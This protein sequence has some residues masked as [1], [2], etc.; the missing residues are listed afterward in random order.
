MDF[1]EIIYLD[2]DHFSDKRANT[3]VGR[4]GRHSIIPR[5]PYCWY[6]YRPLSSVSIKRYPLD[7]RPALQAVLRTLL[8]TYSSFLSSILV[9]PPSQTSDV[10]P[11][12]QRLVE[13]MRVM[14]QNI[15][16][17][18]NDLRPVQVSWKIHHL[19][20][21]LTLLC[22]AGEKQLRDYD[23]SSTR[24]TERRD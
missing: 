18:A 12:W 15:M 13:W 7:R 1:S 21:L 14:G 16:G 4:D 19:F 23:E 5:G 17:A 3:D 24:T 2:Y 22:Y 8:H 9:P 11:D 6:V 20:L 10:P